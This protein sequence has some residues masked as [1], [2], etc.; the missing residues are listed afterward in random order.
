MT[1]FI[2][3]LSMTSIVSYSIFIKSSVKLIRKTNTYMGKKSS[4]YNYLLPCVQ[5]FSIYLIYQILNRCLN[6]HRKQ[7]FFWHFICKPMKAK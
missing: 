2:M 6:T 1:G 7:F 3:N 4:L 5:V